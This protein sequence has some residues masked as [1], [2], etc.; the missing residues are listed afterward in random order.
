MSEI[1][2]ICH[3]S[4]RTVYRYINVISAAH[5]PVTFDHRM[6][7][8]RLLTKNQN[9]LDKFGFDEAILLVLALD[10]LFERVNKD[11]KSII[12]NMV[13]K[14]MADQESAIETVLEGFRQTRYRWEK[15]EDLSRMLTDLIIRCGIQGSKKMRV[16]L[17]SGSD[18][19]IDLNGAIMSFDRTWHLQANDVNKMDTFAIDDIKTVR[20]G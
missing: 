10:L 15:A 6:G 12:K 20:S 5:F 13:A 17:K 3:I 16:T 9:H 11:Y 8:Y 18:R 2:R 4:E 1:K 7:G 14:I 19:Q